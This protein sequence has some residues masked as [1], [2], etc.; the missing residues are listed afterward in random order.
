MPDRMADPTVEA[1]PTRLPG[2]TDAGTG[3]PALLYVP[4]WC[5]DRSVFDGLLERAS[6]HRH[7]VSVD[8]PGHGDSPDP[9]D[10]GTAFVVDTLVAEMART[11]ITRVVPVAM[12]HAGW[13]AVELRRR[14]GPDLV[15]GVVLLD[16]MVLGTPPGFEDAL[17][18]L[19]GPDW[20]QVNARL[21]EMWTAGLDLPDLQRYVDAM[22]DYGRLHWA[23]AGREIAAAFA[24]SPVPLDA[25]EALQPFP[26]LH[27]Y[28][29]PADDA[30]LTAQQEYAAQRPWFS[31]E[32]LDARS[33][34]PMF[35]VP[36]VMADRIETF[37]AG[38]R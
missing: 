35:E 37:V 34:V 7:A 17:A 1:S 5:G 19:Q 6:V 20:A 33:H 11:G 18:A 31:V 10:Y 30:A 26:T 24:E 28:A 36:D 2:C 9:G 22:G 4:G 12:S 8:L 29:Q 27:L 15:P 38:L 13:A 32:R 3:G 23:R 25:I 16:W 21:R 14:L